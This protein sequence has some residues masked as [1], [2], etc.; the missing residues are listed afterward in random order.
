M[1][2]EWSDRIASA[3]IARYVMIAEA[4]IVSVGRGVPSV[5]MWSD[6]DDHVVA[7]SHLQITP[8][9]IRTVGGL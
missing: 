4:G 3:S 2:L 7:T 8:P 9:V 5:S 1:E 6:V